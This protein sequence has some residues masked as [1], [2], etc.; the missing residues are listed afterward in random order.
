[1]IY[2]WRHPREH[3]SVGD[4]RRQPAGS[5]P[6]GPADDGRAD[7]PLRRPLRPG[8]QLQRADR[9]PRRVDAA[10]GL[11]HA[12]PWLFLPIKAGN[13]RLASFFALMESTS[14]AAPLSGPMTLDSWLSAADG[15]A[16]GL[17][18]MSLHGRPRLPRRVRLGRRGGRGLAA[19]PGRGRLLLGRRTTAARSSAT[20][21]PT[22]SGP[23]A[24]GRRVAGQPGREPV[25]P[26][27]DLERGDAPDRRDARLRD[28]GRERDQGAPAAPAQ[29]PPGR[30]G[31]SSGTRRLLELR[32]GGQQPAGQHVPRQR[33]GRRLALH[34]S[35]RR[36]HA[37]CHRRR[38]SPRASLGAWS[39]SRSSPSS[40][41]CG[42]PAASTSEDA[43]GGRPA[44]RC[45]RC[46][47]S[48]SAWAAGSSAS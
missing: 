4:D 41:C 14:E 19:M 8:R 28:P 5:L 33:P 22:S 7:R 12:G 20:P 36:L 9:R 23:G 18:F 46:T 27:A 24:A 13:V 15:D 35:D 30:A 10:H 26:R 3:R 6:L 37:R 45:G 25:Q 11:A 1:M 44:R 43:S 31:R 29:R 32:A 38:R 2:S 40:R 17:W 21:A 34:A 48:C 16:S 42:W 47:R 39:A